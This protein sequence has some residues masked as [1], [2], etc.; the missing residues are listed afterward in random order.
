M[1]ALVPYNPLE[2]RH[3]AESV[4][5]ALLHRPI[6][7]L[8]PVQPFEGAGIY[9]IYYTGD[10]PAYSKVADKNRD[11]A[12]ALPIYIGKADPMGGRRGGDFDAPHGRALWN[13][14]ADHA[15]SVAQADNLRSEDFACRFLAVDDVWIRMAERMLISW[16]FPVWNLVVDGFGNHDPGGRR[17]TQYRSPWDVLHPGRTWAVKLADS[18][19]TPEDIAAK[20]AGH[21]ETRER[22]EQEQAAANEASAQA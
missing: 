20:V 11:G 15:K 2:K 3:L 19:V 14:L 9:A 16:H 18:G 12:F 1:S 10:F 6:Q 5:N 22:A 13:R 8:A 4:A 21:L 7:P 17:A